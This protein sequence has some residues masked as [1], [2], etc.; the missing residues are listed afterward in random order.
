MKKSYRSKIKD[1][2]DFGK[3]EQKGIVTLLFLIL[4]VI[5]L[6]LTL[7]YFIKKKPGD[8]SAYRK[9]IEDFRNS[10]IMNEDSSNR[11][12]RQNVDYNDVDRSISENSLHPFPF[13]PNNLPEEK[14]KQLGMNDKQIKIIKNFEAKGGKFYKKEDLQKIYGITESDYRA[15]EPFIE[16]PEQQYDKKKFEVKELKAPQVIEINA[17]DSNQLL[18]V[19]GIGPFYAR[20]IIK[21]RDRLGGFIRKEQLLEVYGMDSTRYNTI[22]PLISIN[23]SAIRKTNLNTAT[24][25]D[26]MKNPYIDFYM[27]GAI[28]KYR[29]KKGKFSSLEE[30]LNINLIYD[31]V[32]R[33]ISPYLSIN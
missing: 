24:F 28:M 17:A 22:K 1:Y 18:A 20:R 15:L 10:M 5:A 30:L 2:F 6:N 23:P 13:N 4:A 32:Y 8:F 7:P 12:Q 26:L 31:E 16:I 14:W 25:K 21:Y 3:T 19:K 9:D 29:Q 33:K 27:A 11:K